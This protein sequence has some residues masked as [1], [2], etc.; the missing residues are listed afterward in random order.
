MLS[1]S[2]LLKLSF[3]YLFFYYPLLGLVSITSG[4]VIERLI[5]RLIL[6]SYRIDEY[7]DCV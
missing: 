6:F 7:I 1:V 5:D 4:A 2:V 3:P